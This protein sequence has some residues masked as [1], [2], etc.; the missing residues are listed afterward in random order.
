[1]IRKTN[2]G[3]KVLSHRTGRCMGIYPSRK[4]AIMRLR[5]VKYFGRVK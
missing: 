5:Q 2:K 3:W 4:K 1:M